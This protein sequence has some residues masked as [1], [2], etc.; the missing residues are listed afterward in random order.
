MIMCGRKLQ[1][2]RRRSKKKKKKNNNNKRSRRGD[3]EEDDEQQRT[4]KSGETKTMV[5]STPSMMLHLE[6]EEEEDGRPPS[7]LQDDHDVVV[8]RLA[9]Q[10]LDVIHGTTHA[11]PI[12]MVLEENAKC[13][14][15]HR[16]RRHSSSYYSVT[17]ESIEGRLR[18]SGFLGGLTDDFRNDDRRG[19]RHD[20]VGRIITI[21]IRDDV[22][23][24]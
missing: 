23:T 10:A 22:S 11:M 7:P 15:W 12:H 6:E 2:F 21:D 1:L 4:R 20:H 19:G 18:R 9:K 3:E 17:Q 24:L 14:K 16:R 8:G 5:M 13:H